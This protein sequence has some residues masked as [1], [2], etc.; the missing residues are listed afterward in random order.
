MIRDRSIKQTR[1]GTLCTIA[2]IVCRW[3]RKVK[4][5]YSGDKMFIMAMDKRSSAANSFILR[6]RI[7]SI[8][9]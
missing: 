5:E 9:V 7:A 6:L 1:V 8:L 3:L 4:L 2:D